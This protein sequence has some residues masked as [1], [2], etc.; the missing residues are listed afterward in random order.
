[1]LQHLEVFLKINCLMFFCSMQKVPYLKDCTS[2]LSTLNSFS[3]TK[4]S[5]KEIK[6]SALFTVPCTYR[7]S[8]TIWC[9]RNF[10]F[11]FILQSQYP[12]H[13][14][15]GSSNFSLQGP[16]KILHTKSQCICRFTINSASLL[17]LL[18][19]AELFWNELILCGIL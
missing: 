6:C 5:S 13:W 17:H 7:C 12:C 2:Q 16:L 10:Y 19:D 15:V 11:L 8:L 9:W 18:A 1:M 14:L 4:L 3:G